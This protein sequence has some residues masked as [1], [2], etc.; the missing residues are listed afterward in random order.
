MRPNHQRAEGRNRA[1]D[2]PPKGVATAP[3]A[4]NETAVIAAQNIFLGKVS[5]T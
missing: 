2:E 5:V 4:T 1:D 3:I